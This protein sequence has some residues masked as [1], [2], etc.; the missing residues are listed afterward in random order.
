MK[1]TRGSLIG[2]ESFD[3]YYKLYCMRFEQ[4]VN[5][6]D[7]QKNMLEDM[8]KSPYPV[9]R[10]WLEVNCR[11][12]RIGGTLSPI[13]HLVA[14]E[15]GGRMQFFELLHKYYQQEKSNVTWINIVNTKN[16]RGHT[17]L[18]YIDYLDR[19]RELREEEREDINKLINFLCKRGGTY[20]YAK[21]KNC[22]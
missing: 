8:R 13:V 5:K 17:L 6:F 3:E 16:T 20:S 12:S 4:L 1:I 19:A 21:N 14:E 15:V 2:D 7:F 22:N 18:D 11:P 10:F 9:D